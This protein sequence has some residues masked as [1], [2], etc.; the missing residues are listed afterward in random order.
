M[1]SSIQ[2]GLLSVG[3]VAVLLSLVA[4]NGD[5]D[6]KNTSQKKF[7]PY[8]GYWSRNGYGKIIHIDDKNLTTYNFNS[9]GCVTNEVENL[10]TSDYLLPLMSKS[11]NGQFLSID[12]VGSAVQKHAKLNQLPD[13]CKN[14]LLDGDTDALVNFDYIWNTFNE[15]YP[16]YEHRP[17][18]WDDIRDEYRSQV[19]SLTTDQELSELLGDLFSQLQDGH[20]GIEAP[21]D[22]DTS[23]LVFR[24]V[25]LEALR[26]SIS[27]GFNGDL[28]SQNLEILPSVNKETIDSLLDENSIGTFMNSSAVSWGSID[29]TVG[30]LR[31]DRMAAMAANALTDPSDSKAAV[32]LAQA[33]L[34]DTVELM[35]EFMDSHKN[36]D[37]IIVDVRFNEGG[38]DKVSEVIASYFTDEERVYGSKEVSSQSAEKESITLTITPSSN[39]NYTK[40]VYL[41]I[42]G[43]T[44]S[45]GEVFAL[46]MKSFPNV[47]A[48][49]EPTWG[50]VSD[51]LDHKL[52][53][54]WTLGLSNETYLNT[55]GEQLEGIGVT[56]D[57]A[58]NPYATVDMGFATNT[59]LD[60]LALENNLIPNNTRSATEIEST[61]G[62]TVLSNG[63]VGLS[64]AVIVDGQIAWKKGFGVK[65]LETQVPITE[66]TVFNTASV[67]KAF[68]GT[69]FAQLI[70]TDSLS[71]D[72]AINDMG[73]EFSVIHPNA[74]D[75]TITM[76]HLVTHTSTIRDNENHTC[77]YFTL[78][79]HTSLTNMLDES[80][81]CPDPITNLESYLAMYFSSETQPNVSSPFVTEEGFVPGTR[82]VYSNVAT[83]LAA[84]AVEKKLNISIAEHVV[85]HILQPLGMVNSQ[86][87][88]LEPD[89]S[90][91]I[92]SLY[93]IDTDGVTTKLPEYSF[94]TFYDGGMN[95]SAHDLAI[96]I[97]AI[98]N[99]GIYNGVRILNAET[100]AHML[101]AQTPVLTHTV[102]TQGIFWGTSG[103]FFGHSGSTL[104][105]ASHMFYNSLTGVGVVL[106]TNT[107][108][109]LS[110]DEERYEAFSELLAPLYRFGLG[111]KANQ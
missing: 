32:A 4:C 100:V 5:N 64:A 29:S 19:S 10:S 56:P 108:D 18:N 57:I 77:S 59:A 104:G 103:S 50:A 76:R 51:V 24:G 37:A 6:D 2:K 95:A 78:N 86:W 89:P 69:A 47:T 27:E 48:I 33:D 7:E 106:L 70:E 96:F 55:D 58:M 83:G 105:A 88:A 3:C 82:Q 38:F 46:A 111:H 92:A 36:K 52:P 97:S 61:I 12:S 85:N 39:H 91:T 102:E 35:N 30:Y 40:P 45:A 72:E 34:N 109:T 21:N 80:Y 93:L 53:N 8:E 44:S 13:V 65:D 99:G 54:G 43:D 42:G 110:G 15:Y 23:T 31:I 20:V 75:T 63:L 74:P 9:Y 17:L 16:E 66:H 71:L 84:H 79:D 28:F 98:A 73:I 90:Q 49:G 60:Y 11:E 87:N 68:L 62:N 107:E 14:K 101:S 22:L 41:I 25:A 94:S 81:N 1:N 26:N 67:S